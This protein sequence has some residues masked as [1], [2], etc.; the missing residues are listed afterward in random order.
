MKD[1]YA[2]I[3]LLFVFSAIIFLYNY[4]IK[5]RNE[6]ILREEIIKEFGKVHSKKFKGKIDGLHKRIGGNLTEITA[7]DLNFDKIIEKINHNVSRLGLEYFYHRLR[8]LILDK[9][10]L[11]KSQNNRNIYKKHEDELLDLQFQLGKIGFF[12]EDVL[13]LVEEEVKID[14]ELEI[15]ANI[16]S[17]TALYI[18]ILFIFL[19]AGSVLFILVLLG[20]NIYIYKKFN[21]ITLGKLETLVR[22]KSILFVSENL[23]KNKS[24]VFTE[25][26]EEIENIL[27]RISPLKKTLKSFGFLT[28]NAEMDFAETYK[29]VLFLSEARKFSKS[30]KYFKEYKDEIFRLYY[31]LGKIDC[32]IGIISIE[33]AYNTGDAIFSE[34]ICGKNLYNPL[35]K[36]AVPNDLDLEKSI[37]L[38]GSNASGKSTYLRT[39]GINAVFA[40]SFGIFFGEKFEIKPLK[41]TSAI[42]ISDSIMKNL[43]YFM[44]ES[45]AII[46]MIEDD[47]EK[48][49]LLDEIFRGTNTIDRIASATSTLKYLAKKNHVVAA[50]HDIELTILLKDYFNNK[51]FE[52]KIEDGDIKFDYLIKDGPATTRNAIAILDSLNYPE[53]IINEARTLSKKMEDR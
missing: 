43:S 45:K 27:K 50:T 51:H 28:G 5:V 38:T 25:E 4:Y 8:N 9:D 21:N 24:Q 42:D 15:G 26:L 20:I 48:L 52:E 30:Q 7:N 23:M 10:E 22:F 33:K 37:I 39:I 13:S 17:F 16:F 44:A 49:I 40:L 47:E 3:I 19:R 34:K 41:V 46:E 53:E 29:N 12:K 36:D 1:Y 2:P 14:R 31:L 32:E 35:L 6:K 18:L 11:I